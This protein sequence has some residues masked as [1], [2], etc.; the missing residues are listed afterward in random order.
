MALRYR[1]DATP[2]VT[3]VTSG[4][5]TEDLFNTIIDIHR[6]A[7]D[8]AKKMF[9]EHLGE[10]KDFDS[11]KAKVESLIGGFIPEIESQITA[12]KAQS[13][14]SKQAILDMIEKTY[15][16]KQALLQNAQAK[17]ERFVDAGSDTITQWISNVRNTLDSAYEKLKRDNQ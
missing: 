9:D 15:G 6:D 10:V 13:E 16:E 17:A 2:S 5:R 3:P 12:L 11:L 1:K 8:A 7:F 14:T 4:S